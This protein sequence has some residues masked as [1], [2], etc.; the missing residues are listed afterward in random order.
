MSESITDL[1]NHTER[2]KF[3]IGT[4]WW[5]D[6]DDVVAMRLFAW[7][8]QNNIIE[9]AGIGINACMEYSCTSLDAFFTAEGLP[10]I[11]IAIDKAAVDY[12]GNPPYQKR[13]AAYRSKYRSNDDCEDA[14]R[15]YRK[16]LSQTDG[17]IEI[18]E[19]GFAQVL[20]NLLKSKADDVSDLTGMEL[21]Q[22]KVKKLWIMAGKWDEPNG[23]RAHNFCKTKRT[24]VAANYLCEN[25]PCPITFLGFEVSEQIRTGDVLKGR[26]NDLVA[27]ALK[28]HGSENGRF[29]WDPM[30]ALLAIT[31]NEKRAGYR[32]V[33]GKA[34]VD[35]ETGANYFT[36]DENGTQCFV[37]KT[38]LDDF[39]KSKINEILIK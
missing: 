17:E 39:Y 13:M 24:S 18:V 38:E 29:S 25:C 28:D 33:S 10:N 6:C 22:K 20:A 19:I 9:I 3:L 34:M 30:L 32:T 12:G 14:V 23:G 11:E 27:N 26:E 21:F 15:M 4:D 5:T 35:A 37:I 36:Q 1:L 16:I 2:R 8:H 7:A 31:G